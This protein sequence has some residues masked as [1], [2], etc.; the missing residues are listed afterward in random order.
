LKHWKKKTCAGLV[1]LGALVWVSP[2]QSRP[3]TATP[4][5]SDSAAKPKSQTTA[6]Q[7]ARKASAHTSQRRST[8]HT[9]TRH[10]SAKARQ[11][12]A[13]RRRAQLRPEP[14]R[15]QEIQQALVQAGYLN[16]EPNGRWDD[17]TREAMRRYQADHGFPVTGLPEAK[18]LMKLG[19]GPHPLPADLDA[20]SAAKAGAD[21]VGGTRATPDAQ[22]NPPTTAPQP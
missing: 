9:A 8:H 16:A 5:K 3:D 17:Q 7:R 13:R 4:Q 20:N 15:I 18:S 10:L 14:E 12:A 21:T 1:L 22:Q 11:A 19:L 2:V 6:K